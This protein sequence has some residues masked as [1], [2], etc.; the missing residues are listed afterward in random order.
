MD[1]VNNVEIVD[2]AD[3]VPSIALGA[4]EDI[5]A[6]K[7]WI[8]LGVKDFICKPVSHDRLLKSIQR[9]HL[10]VPSFVSVTENEERLKAIDKM[11]K[12]IAPVFQKIGIAD[13]IAKQLICATCNSS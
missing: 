4:P 5:S 9:A 11:Q 10:K 8:K 12:E 2:I 1:F 13:D 7:K 3:A 6:V